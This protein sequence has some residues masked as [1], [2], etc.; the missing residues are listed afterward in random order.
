M[1]TA[2][3]LLLAAMLPAVGQTAPD[4][5][6][7]VDAQ[8]P[9]LVAT[10]KNLHQHPEL[11][12]Y[13]ARTSAFLAAE[14]RKAGYEVTEQVG[15]Y[16][17]GSRAYGVVAAMKND[18]GPTVLVRTDLDALPIQEETGL[19]YASSEHGQT[20]EGNPA[21]AM[22]ACGHDIHMASFLGA[23]RVLAQLKDQWRGTLI[24][25]GQPSEE[26]IDGAR[27]MLADGLYER[28]GRPDYVLGQHDDPG[29]PAGTAGIVSGPALASST[30]VDV[31]IR[32]IG[33]HGARPEA[34][35]DPIVMAAEYILDIQTIVSRQLP[36]QQPA[37]VT[38]GTIHGGTKRNIIPDVVTLQLTVRTYSDEVREKILDSLRKMA[39]GMA[40]ANGLPSDRM[41]VVSVSKTEATPVTYNDPALA[42]RLRPVFIAALGAGNVVD[43]HA[44]MGSEDFGLFGLPGHQIPAFFLRLGATDPAKLAESRRTGA[45]VPGLHSALF[46]PEP[47]PTIRT[48]VIGMS[49]A[50]LDLMKK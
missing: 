49:A 3:V 23:G 30:S 14:L 32:G 48:G 47:A 20:L 19:S 33:G 31:A 41:P 37:V 24:L 25:I 42:A 50:V 46:A 8:L 11:S 43:W 4:L 1:K 13:E 18:P 27:A 44:E 16:P 34:G 29:L 7:L 12:H 36:P 40:V 39:Q 28:F 6:A 45:P 15:V 9:S 22:H 2:C 35:K 26:T 38:V 10:Y 5:A 21:S 17:D